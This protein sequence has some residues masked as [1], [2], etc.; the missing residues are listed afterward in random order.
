MSP[1]SPVSIAL[2]LEDGVFLSNAVVIEKVQRAWRGFNCFAFSFDDFRHYSRSMTSGAPLRFFVNVLSP[3]MALRSPMAMYFMT[4]SMQIPF[5]IAHSAAMGEQATDSLS[6]N[7]NAIDFGLSEGVLFSFL[8]GMVFNEVGQMLLSKTEYFR[9]F[10][11]W[12]DGAIIVLLALWA[13]TLLSAVR[14]RKCFR[15]P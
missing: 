3:S 14:G 2:R 1:G 4:I 15:S 11:N 6:G 12:V 9:N 10:W 8:V 5:L 13:I 7:V